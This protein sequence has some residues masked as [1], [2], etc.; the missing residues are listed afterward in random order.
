VLGLPLTEHI[1]IGSVHNENFRHTS[2]HAP[3]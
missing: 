3:R 1:Q 2:S